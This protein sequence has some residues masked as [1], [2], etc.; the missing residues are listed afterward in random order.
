ML[1][2]CPDCGETLD[3]M[4]LRSEHFPVAQP[5]ALAKGAPGHDGVRLLLI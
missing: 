1:E 5:G 3:V 2:R 4:F